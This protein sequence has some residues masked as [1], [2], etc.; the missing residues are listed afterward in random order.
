M[1]QL[2]VAFAQIDS[3][4]YTDCTFRPNI[5]TVILQQEGVDGSS[6][7]IE[8]NSGTRLHLQFDDLDP[9]QRQ[10]Y[11]SLEHCNGDW[12]PSRVM[13]S[14]A[15]QGLQQ[16]FVQDFE[17]SFNTRQQYIHYS[18]VFPSNQ[19]EI[20][21]SGNYIIKVFED[22]NPDNIVL[23]RRFM[24]FKQDASVSASVRRTI[25]V[26]LMDT[27]QEV[28][29][30]VNIASLSLINVPSSTKLIIRQN[31]RWDNAISL[32]P[33]SFNKQSINYNYD[34]GRNCFLSGN[35]FR[36]ADI[37]S[38][39]M[40]SDRVSNFQRDSDLVVTNLLIDP[41]RTFDSYRNLKE[42]NGRFFIRN[43]DGTEPEL[44]A[45][46]TWVKFTLPFEA[47]VVN[48]NLFIFGALSDWNFKDEFKLV[49]DYPSKSYRS[50]ILLKQGIYNYSYIFLP[51]NGSVGDISYIE[52]SHFETENDYMIFFYTRQYTEVF[53]ELVGISQINSRGIR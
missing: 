25:P 27:H 6:P 3:L 15:I 1:L 26:N 40:Q 16:D 46:Y 51:S 35:E 19:M 42:A 21:L 34:D 24:V 41:L 9:I 39:R 4:R 48:G 53:D 12:K 36:W 20:L 44:D 11:Y 18:L 23:T 32:T 14:R 43:S 8:L 5:R 49:Y 29:V 28:D 2:H 10:Y 17:Y 50:R 30:N 38:L 7:L 22:G 33:L 52:G 31:G 37:R 45:D 47:P 13:L